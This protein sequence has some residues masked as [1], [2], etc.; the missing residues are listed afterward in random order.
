MKFFKIF[1]VIL[2]MTITL[3]A[4]T[5]KEQKMK[6]VSEQDSISYSIGQSIGKNLSDP[7]F[8]LNYEAV[9]EGIKD[10]M[11][12]HTSIMAEEDMNKV[13]T[14]FNNKIMSKRNAVV[15]ELKEKNAALSQAFLEANK[16]KEGVTVLP[17][18]LQYKVIT[19]GTGV[20]PLAT[21]KVK[22]HYKGTLITGEEFDSSYKRGEPTEFGV[23]QVIKGWTEALQLMK[24]GDKWELFIPA[25]LA[26]GENGA[27]QMIGPNSAL[28]FEVELLE[29]VK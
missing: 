23:N 15:N 10:A 2:L 5:K 24:V 7:S 11:V 17:D 14:T 27:G 21:D 16:Q 8:D 9:V 12:N 4:Q 28:V 26:Y 13:M 22:V 19:T 29:I 1:V 18:G 6:L 3:N 25:E 20:S